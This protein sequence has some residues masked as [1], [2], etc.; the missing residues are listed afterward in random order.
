MNGVKDTHQHCQLIEFANNASSIVMWHV[1]NCNKEDSI[2][3]CYPKFTFFFLE[4]LL[5][6][7]KLNNNDKL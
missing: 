1:P 6:I 3:A 7:N 5:P 2:L 4:E